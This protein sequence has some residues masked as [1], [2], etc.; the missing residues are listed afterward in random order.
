[1]NVRNC[2]SCGKLFNY[3]T[4]A[5]VCPVCRQAL[6]AKFQVVKQYIRDHKG[7]GIQ[8]VSEACEV[9]PGQ[10]R[11]WLR[12]DRLEVTEDSA[13]MLNC[14]SCG[15]PIRSG[16]FCDRCKASMT[17]SFNSILSANKPV[18]KPENANNKTNPKMRYLDN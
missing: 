10:I 7:V 14:E 4:G 8:E 3:I 17:N 18:Q 2:K 5:P 11:T 15:T 9:E 1:M 13:L 12:E 6:E 16:R